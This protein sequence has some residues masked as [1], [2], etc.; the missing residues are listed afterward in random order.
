[1]FVTYLNSN[2][3]HH[4]PL[5][6]FDFSIVLDTFHLTLQFDSADCTSSDLKVTTIKGN[7]ELLHKYRPDSSWTCG[8][9]ELLSI[10]RVNL[11]QAS[12]SL[13]IHQNGHDYT[14]YFVI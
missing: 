3:L 8:L 5:N 14:F 1:M 10:W 6:F 13:L 12:C 11:K 9:H 7:A 4:F 2:R